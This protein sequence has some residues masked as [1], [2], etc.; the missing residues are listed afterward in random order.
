MA[1]SQYLKKIAL[2]G[3]ANLAPLN[4]AK[5]APRARI[6]ELGKET[7]AGW[8]G[9]VS[10]PWFDYNKFIYISSFRTNQREILDAVQ[11]AN[12]TKDEDWKI[13]HRDAQKYLDEG[14][15]LIDKGEF[16]EGLVRRLYGALFIDGLGGDYEPV[17]GLQ[18][19]LLGLEQ[20]DLLQT[21]SSLIAEA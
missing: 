13:E 11:T 19:E 15:E 12:K 14:L 6:E 21:V 10:N 8:I 16:L 4:A 1:D 2:F 3:L 17:R 9:I 20:E 7:G 18:N 5:A